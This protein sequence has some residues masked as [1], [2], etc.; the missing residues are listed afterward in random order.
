MRCWRRH[1]CG[2]NARRSS[3]TWLSNPIV[4]LNP[5]PAQGAFHFE[6]MRQLHRGVHTVEV[7][8]LRRWRFTASAMN[9]MSSREVP[10]AWLHAATGGVSQER[11]MRDWNKERVHVIPVGDQWGVFHMT[12]VALFDYSR[13]HFGW[14]VALHNLHFLL[15]R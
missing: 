6:C 14:R 2:T 9:K 12:T 3:P 13:R 8:P 15:F 10:P 11:T 1:S 4:A 7:R 5:A